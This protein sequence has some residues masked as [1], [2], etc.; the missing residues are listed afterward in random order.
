MAELKRIQKRLQMDITSLWEYIGILISLNINE[1]M[2]I[3]GG[4]YSGLNGSE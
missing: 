2:I 3:A 1:R 4:G